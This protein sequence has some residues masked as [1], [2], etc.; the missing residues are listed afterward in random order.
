MSEH[1]AKPRMTCADYIAA[2]HN[3]YEFDG[4]F[5][6]LYW[7]EGFSSGR[8]WDYVL[9]CALMD[10]VILIDILDFDYETEF[11]ELWQCSEKGLS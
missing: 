1:I 6:Y 2:M 5:D 4:I 10:N 11:W 7:G 3:N 9:D 8:L